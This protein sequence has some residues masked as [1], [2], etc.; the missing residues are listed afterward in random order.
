MNR[1]EDVVLPPEA[2]QLASEN[3]DYGPSGASITAHPNPV[4]TCDKFG[5]CSVTVCYTFPK[6]RSVEIRIGSPDGELF[7]LPDR[8]GEKVTGNWVTDGMIF[9]MQDV[10]D[11]NPLTVDHTLAT[12]TVRVAGQDALDKFEPTFK[13]SS[14]RAS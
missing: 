2:E 6:G 12:V 9:F 8:N 3:R 1:A 4:Y 11:G 10:S 5:A 14:E 13:I 7:A